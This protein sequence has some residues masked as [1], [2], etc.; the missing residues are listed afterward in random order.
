MPKLP[1]I[2]G[3]EAVRALQRL[4]FEVARQK[5][6]HI[7]MRRGASGCVVPNHRE[8]KAGTLAGAL[9]QAGISIPEFDSALN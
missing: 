6:S 7:V 1:R 2:S 5:G 8:L 3:A 4:G 9:R